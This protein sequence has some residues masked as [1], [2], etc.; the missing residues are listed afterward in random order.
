MCLSQEGDLLEVSAPAG[1]FFLTPDSLD[2]SVPQ[3]SSISP[4]IHPSI[5]FPLH[6]SIYPCPP[7][8]IHP[9]I[10][11]LLYPSLHSSSG[12]YRG[13]YRDHPPPQ[14]AH[15]SS[16][17]SKLEGTLPLTTRPHLS[18]FSSISPTFSLSHQ[19][20]L[21]LPLILSLTSPPLPS[22]PIARQF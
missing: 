19:L 16:C 20:R 21:I 9:S 4:C 12:V 15:Y 10:H 2:S 1:D 13:R 5:H 6:P 7:T 11:L 22:H 3:V 14:Y 17:L 18:T 8:S